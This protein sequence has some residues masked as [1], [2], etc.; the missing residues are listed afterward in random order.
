LTFIV[1]VGLT[2]AIR[3]MQS[4]PDYYELAQT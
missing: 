3:A 2:C 1:L 4:N